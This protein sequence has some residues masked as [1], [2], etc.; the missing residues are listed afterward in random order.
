M[1]GAVI[2]VVQNKLMRRFRQVGATSPASAC[3]PEDIG[4]RNSWIFRRLAARRV[5]VEA[6]PGRYY[7]DEMAADEFVRMRR[8]RMLWILA[9]LLALCALMVLATSQL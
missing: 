9:V 7:I 1:S 2:V 4:C 5:F 3:A 6:K 8:A